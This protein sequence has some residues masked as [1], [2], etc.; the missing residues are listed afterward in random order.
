MTTQVRTHLVIPSALLALAPLSAFS[1]ASTSQPARNE[2]VT[3]E[4]VVVTSQKREERLIDVPISIAV[5][6]SDELKQRQITTLEDLPQVVP[7]LAYNNIGNNHYFEIRGISN[8]I[9][10]SPLVGIYIDEADATLGGAAATQI[11]P[12]VYDLERVEVLRG[13]QGTLYGQ[14]SAGGTIRFVTR[15][16]DLNHLTFGADVAAMFTEHG[17]PSQRINTVTNIPL[18]EDKLGLRIVGTFQHD[19]GWI[20]QPAADRQDINDQNLTNVRIKGLWKITPEFTASVLAIINRSERGTDVSDPDSKYTWTQVFNLTNTPRVTNNNDLYNLTLAYD[21]TTAKLIN[22]TTSLSVHAPW[23]NQSQRYQFAPAGALPL[24]DYYGPIQNTEDRMWTDEL[25]LTSVGSGPWQ[26]TIGGFYRHYRDSTSIPDNY[27]DIPGPVG[28]PLPDPYSFSVQTLYKSWS[29]FANTSYRLWDRLT[30]GVGL[31]YF[32][33]HQ[34]FTDRVA[35]TQQADTFT[36]VDP[37]VFAEFALTHGFNLYASAAKGFR[38]GGFNA[39]NQPAYDPESV[40]TYELGAKTSLV[41]GRLSFDTA[42]F[43]SD[44]KNYQTFGITDASN[45]ENF[46]ADVGSARIKGLEWDLTYRPFNDWRFDVRGD[47]VNARF[48]AINATSSNY[49]VGD[50]LDLVPRY[51]LSTSAQYDYLLLGKAA[52]T[53]LD[54]SRQGPETS[55]NR[56]IGP[57]YYGESDVINRLNFNSTLSWSDALQVGFFVQNLLNDQGFA[58]PYAYIYSGVR[59]RPRTYGVNFSV[60]LR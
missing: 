17:D 1:Q 5:V 28:S 39:E 10:N 43:W 25:R 29:V 21:F 4:E 54:Y 52:S 18:I 26:W 35:L 15:D 33:D 50:P 37:R 41:D 8:I 48:T 42:V 57:W 51:Q 34:D 55:R 38:S 47:Y 49:A 27:F 22:T 56:S 59:P 30:L 9:G 44:Y 32:N 11:N 2:E 46:I 13:P 3:L 58:N 60:S 6:G 31:R 20:D 16:P 40:W 53:R 24:F 45:G 12:S 36:S 14:G 7:N 19:G 23:T